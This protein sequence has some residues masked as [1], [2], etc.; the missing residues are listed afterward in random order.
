M[1]DERRADQQISLA[2]AGLAAV[3]QLVG[4]GEVGLRLRA[5]IRYPGQRSRGASRQGLGVL[6][7]ARTEPGEPGDQ[8]VDVR[9]KDQAGLIAAT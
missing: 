9:Q 7:I 4:R 1:G 6:T 5:G 3:K 8:R 2:A